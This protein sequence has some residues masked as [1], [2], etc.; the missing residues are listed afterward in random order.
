VLRLESFLFYTSV[1][2]GFYYIYSPFVVKILL[3]QKFFCFRCYVWVN[4]CCEDNPIIVTVLS[5]LKHSCDHSFYVYIHVWLNSVVTIFLLFLRVCGTWKFVKFTNFYKWSSSTF[6]CST[7]V[8]VH[9][10]SLYQDSSQQNKISSVR[11]SYNC[12]SVLRKMS[13]QK[14]YS[15]CADINGIKG[16]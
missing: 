9:F 3:W 12:W 6:L 14:P 10:N 4:L 7:N 2:F 8:S 5:W 1:A 16:L 15:G 13:G 11:A